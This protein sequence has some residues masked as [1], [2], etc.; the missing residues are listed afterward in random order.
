MHE[1][2]I[3]E[4][5]IARVEGEVRAR[6]AAHVQRVHVRIGELSGVEPELLASAYAIFREHTLCRGAELSIERVEARWQCGSC[7]AALVS[8]GMLR[9][10]VCGGVPHLTQ[11]DE[12]IL[13]RIE[14]EME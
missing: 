3:I 8:G 4:T 7:G 2:S 1:Y 14:M 12:I 5:L 9:C 11:G 10:G 13:E 6:N